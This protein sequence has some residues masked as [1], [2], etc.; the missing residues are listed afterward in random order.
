MI[1]YQG[2]LTV[3]IRELSQ[4]TAAATFGTDLAHHS[5]TVDA[6]PPRAMSRMLACFAS[7]SLRYQ[8]SCLFGATR[9]RVPVLSFNQA[10]GGATVSTSVVFCL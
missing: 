5:L 10:V 9:L 7:Q 1:N 3:Y 4:V 8:S 6:H 2:D